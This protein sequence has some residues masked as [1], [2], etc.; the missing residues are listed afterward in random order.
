M[1]L[2]VN[3]SNIKKDFNFDNQ[4]YHQELL[5]LFYNKW[6]SQNNNVVYQI[7]NEDTNNV[8]KEVIGAD[9]QD[10]LQ[11]NPQYKHK[12]K[13]GE[14]VW[15]RNEVWQWVDQTYGEFVNFF[16]QLGKLNQQVC[17]GGFLQYYTNGYASEESEGAFFNYEGDISLHQW[18][19]EKLQEWL[20]LDDDFKQV[21]C[22]QSALKIFQQFTIETDADEYIDN[23]Y[24][25]DEEE[26]Y[27]EEQVENEFYGEVINQDELNELD[28]RYYAIND[29][30]MN[31]INQFI[32]VKF[33]QL[34]GIS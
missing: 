2:T 26:M 22:I 3:K 12:L 14:I 34:F 16:V 20:Q 25:D 5:N 11:T 7:I 28:N 10:E 23:Q 24:W 4:D 27:V 17:N 1:K 18:M 19:T 15:G 32:K 29:E 6:Q 31:S 21:S 30:F 13:E 33:N 9:L 8:V